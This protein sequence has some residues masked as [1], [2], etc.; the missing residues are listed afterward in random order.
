MR[1]TNPIKHPKTI[2][3][4]KIHITIPSKK[5]GNQP[6]HGRGWKELA[7]KAMDPISYRN[8]K[9]EALEAA[10][11][12]EKTDEKLTNLLT[13]IRDLHDLLLSPNNAIAWGTKLLLFERFNS[14]Y[15][16]N[17]PLTPKTL[18]NK[19][20]DYKKN[21]TF[22]QKTLEEKINEYNNLLNTNKNNG[23]FNL[24]YA[25]KDAEPSNHDISDDP[26]NLIESYE[27]TD[28]STDEY[29]NPHSL[30]YKYNNM[31][32]QNQNM[33]M[34]V[35]YFFFLAIQDANIHRDNIDSVLMALKTILKNPEQQGRKETSH[36]LL[37]SP[38]MTFQEVILYM[39]RDTYETI[40]AVAKQE[41]KEGDN[42]KK[43]ELQRLVGCVE[44]L[45]LLYEDIKLSQNIIE[46]QRRM[47]NLIGNNNEIDFQNLT[48][49]ILP[50]ESNDPL[51]YSKGE[52]IN[53]L[54]QNDVSSRNL[55]AEIMN[56]N[57]N[58]PVHDVSSFLTSTEITEIEKE[59]LKDLQTNNLQ[60]NTFLGF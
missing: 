24:L 33:N 15:K 52:D 39:Y 41:E 20:E 43:S 38:E 12:L 46:T 42:F 5:T 31:F 21:I 22:I 14:R 27:D 16:P 32:N 60:K 45:H 36:D 30:I 57:K 49:A 17:I 2:G 23:P 4:P 25:N 29:D 51:V 3:K 59:L 48:N 35:S 58:N 28:G 11:L 54:K 7:Y 18:Q 53:I 44:S 13:E 37:E 50:S 40:E 55:E 26:Y 47:Q 1:S 9:I 34:A 19:I 56:F 10:L 6:G 8:K